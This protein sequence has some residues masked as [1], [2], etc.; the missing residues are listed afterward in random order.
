MTEFNE[1]FTV[2]FFVIFCAGFSPSIM[3]DKHENKRRITMTISMACAVYVI[4]VLIVALTAALW[5]VLS[6]NN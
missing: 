1:T 2:S 4:G 3:E 6:G 5:D